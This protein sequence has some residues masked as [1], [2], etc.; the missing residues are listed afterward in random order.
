VSVAVQDPAYPVYVDTSVILGMTG[1][2]N[3]DRGGFDN[4]EYMPCRCANICYTCILDF[5]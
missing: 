4:I 2:Y 5:G 1:T 3:K